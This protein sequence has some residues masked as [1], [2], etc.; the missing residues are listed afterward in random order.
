MRRGGAGS[1][2]EKGVLSSDKE[3][4]AAAAGA[5]GA[6]LVILWQGGDRLSGRAAGVNK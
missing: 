2:A 1:D 5:V 6:A 4:S 3:G